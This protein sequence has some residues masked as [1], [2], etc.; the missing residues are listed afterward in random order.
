MA[1]R[2]DRILETVMRLPGLRRY[3]FELDRS[4]ARLARAEASLAE[5]RARAERKLAAAGAR[6]TA[7]E[8]RRDRERARRHARRALQRQRDDDKLLRERFFLETLARRAA[9]RLSRSAGSDE[10]R[11][12]HDALLERS[13]S[14]RDACAQ[15]AETGAD[16]TSATVAGLIW[17]VPTDRRRPGHLADRIL[18]GGWLPLRDLQATRALAV[19]DTMIDIGANVGTTAVPRVLLGDVRRVF[20]AEPDPANYACLVRNVLDN[21][22]AG[23]VLPDRIAI[24]DADGETAFLAGDQIGVGRLLAA[25]VAE[26]PGTIA[27]ACRTLDH[28]VEAMGIDLAR[29]A[30]I[31]SDTQGWEAR[32]LAGAAEVLSHRHI[33]WEV[34][35]DPKLLG[36]AGDD[37]LAFCDLI[38][39][40]FSHFIDLR[41]PGGARHVRRSDELAGALSYITVG[42]ARRYTDLLLLNIGEERAG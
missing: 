34:E 14:Y 17:W 6:V 39:R 19:G 16:T 29:V 35:F 37:P 40:H 23:R 38:G 1:A 4:R 11:D 3:R 8:A 5:V 15:P 10:A 9:S 22:L 42:G 18:T 33:V 27:V 24:S 12:A 7:L 28:W 36:R 13:A 31:K 25:K 32:V 2:I 21:G 41:A 20:A 30:F 26:R